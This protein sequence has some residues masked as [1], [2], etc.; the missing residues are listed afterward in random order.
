MNLMDLLFHEVIV[1]DQPLRRGHY[2]ATV[3]DRLYRPSQPFYLASQRAR[4]PFS[5]RL[6]LDALREGHR[7]TSNTTTRQEQI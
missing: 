3:I 1:I 4:L 5:A 6:T 7:A 2:G